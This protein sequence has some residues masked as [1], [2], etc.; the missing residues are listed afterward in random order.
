VWQGRLAAL[1]EGNSL[2]QIKDFYTGDLMTRHPA[3]EQGATLA[4]SGIEFG[5]D[6]DA[7]GAINHL[8]MLVA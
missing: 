1:P 6:Y 4:E 8:C 5:A 3:I 7:L 2:A